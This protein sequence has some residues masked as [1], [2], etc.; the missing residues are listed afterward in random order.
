MQQIIEEILDLGSMLIKKVIKSM[1]K[2][3]KFWILVLNL[4]KKYVKN[5]FFLK[6]IKTGR[7]G[8]KPSQTEKPKT[9]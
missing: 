5:N 3:Q 9:D 2:T 7:T 4:I 1:L 8:P 6:V